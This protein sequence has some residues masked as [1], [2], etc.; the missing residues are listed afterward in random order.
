METITIKQIHTKRHKLQNE[1]LSYDL[2]QPSGKK[3]TNFLGLR[4]IES[5]RKVCTFLDYVNLN[6]YNQINEKGPRFSIIK[7]YILVQ[8]KI[9]RHFRAILSVRVSHSGQPVN[10]TSKYCIKITFQNLHNY[11]PNG[12]KRNHKLINTHMIKRTIISCPVDINDSNLY[13]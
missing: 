11:T 9:R 5:M 7:F 13:N 6:I 3:Y 2:Q 10:L 1:N 12:F 4:L 8:F